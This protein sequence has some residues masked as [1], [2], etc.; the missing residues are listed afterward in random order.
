[1]AST[2]LNPVFT[3]SESPMVGPVLKV[4]AFL[5]NMR[6]E[7]KHDAELQ[8]CQEELKVSEKNLRASEERRKEAESQRNFLVL[9]LLVILAAG[10]IVSIEY[11]MVPRTLSA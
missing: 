2:I 4:L 11:Q 6:R 3:A 10:V 8:E 5:I 1:M 9:C 7:A